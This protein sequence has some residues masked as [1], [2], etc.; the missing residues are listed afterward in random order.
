MTR[1]AI[2]L[3]RSV[4]LRLTFWYVLAF[5][6]LLM[7]FSFYVL[8]FVSDDLRHQFDKQLIN[9]AANTG[10]YFEEFAEKQNIV[11]GARETI[12]ELQHD[13]EQ[14]A[15]FHDN[16]LLAAT[17]NEVVDLTKSLHLFSAGSE[18]ENP[19]LGTD[20]RANTRVVAVSLKVNSVRYT[21]VVAASMQE[22][23]HELNNLRRI[24]LFALPA[25]LLLV[26]VGGF[27]LA[28]KSLKPVIAISEQAERI[29]ARNLSERLNV[30]SHDEFGRLAAVFNALLSRL[31]N[32]FR[33]M[34]EFMA[35]ASHELRTPLAIIH[36]EAE[37]SLSRERTLAEY[38]ESLAVI[39][40]NSKRMSVIVSDMLDLARADSGQQMLRK[41]ELYLD[42][43]IT[44]CCRGAQPLAQM[45]QIAL[46]CRTQQ[47]VSFYGD[48][49]LLKRMAMN[50]LYNAIQ[51]TPPGGSVS[52]ELTSENGWSRLRVV[53]NGVGIDPDCVPRVFDRFYRIAE[54]RSRAD[55]GSGLGLAIVKLAAESHGGEVSVS[56][57]PR[58]GST[59]TV[60]LPLHADGR[61]KY[62]LE[63]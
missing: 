11:G 37:V 25:A 29:S 7:A 13:N 50:L 40:D 21:A 27:L 19:R 31:D 38:R 56:S 41:Q 9:A 5:G 44:N 3:F 14:L 20:S 49:E 62:I 8:S 63:E 43:L 58:C 26:A 16:D 32:S 51:Y 35:D 55:G 42:D 52:V 15:I 28:G 33:V 2:P 39:R 12:R 30:K 46:I 57:E 4:R 24:I 10:S 48:E 54:S 47:D 6:G 59:F 22:L 53:D 18:P 36:G 17:G 23:T 34:R 61:T 1:E 45:K 60:S